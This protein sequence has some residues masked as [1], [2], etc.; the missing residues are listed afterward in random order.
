MNPSSLFATSH[1]TKTS[2][3]LRRSSAKPSSNDYLLGKSASEPERLIRQAELY[4]P[5]ARQLLDAVNLTTGQRALD[6]GCGPLGILDEMAERVGAA[7]SV[8]GLEREETYRAHAET[9][10]RERG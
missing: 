7:G 8:I 3:D 5:E 2:L 10:L 6:L 9:T 1:L 4:R